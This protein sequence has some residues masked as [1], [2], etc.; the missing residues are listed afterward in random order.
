[1]VSGPGQK[2]VASKLHLLLHP[3]QSWF[4]HDTSNICAIIGLFVGLFFNLYTFAIAGSLK[5]SQPTPYTVSVEKQTIPPS[6]SFFA[7]SAYDSCE[8]ETIP[9][10]LFRCC[11]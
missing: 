2:R 10:I 5:V 4:V 7:A 3:E 6:R 1:M 9:I 11:F 8:G